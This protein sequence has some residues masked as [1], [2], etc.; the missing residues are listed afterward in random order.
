MLDYSILNNKKTIKI[1]S[2]DKDEEKVNCKDLLSTS[3]NHTLPLV[4]QICIV[5]KYY[6]GR[7][8]LISLAWYNDDKY[9]DIICKINGISNPFEL[10]END[11]LCMPPFED[12]S[13]YLSTT[14]L[15]ADDGL[16][17][18]IYKDDS[19]IT[20]VKKLVNERRSPNEKVIGEENYIIDKTNHLIF[21]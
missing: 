14:G 19:F 6:V 7:P 2:N 11:I 3:F 10:N 1:N 21:Y 17:E 15:N 16:A 13:T 8:D 9:A 20:K 4:G 18:D 12:L 5:N